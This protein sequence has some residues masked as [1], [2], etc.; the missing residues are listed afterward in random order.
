[1]QQDSVKE[2]QNSESVKR[3]VWFIFSALGSQW[4]G[5]GICL[6]LIYIFTVNLYNKP[7]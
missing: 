3:P 5:M 7:L 6:K 2:I 4:P 1:L